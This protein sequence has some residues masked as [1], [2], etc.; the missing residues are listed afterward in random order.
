M[1]GHIGLI[2]E[3]KG[4]GP[5]MFMTFWLFFIP[6]VSWEKFFL[7]M[8]EKHLWLSVHPDL[9]HVRKFHPIIKPEHI[10]QVVLEG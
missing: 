6:S 1:Y 4:A 7:K 9:K 2:R 5:D 8:Q 10:F 3:E